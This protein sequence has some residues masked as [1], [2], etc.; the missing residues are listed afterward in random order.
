[1]ICISKLK[2]LLRANPNIIKDND[3]SNRLQENQVI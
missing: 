3:I 2:S 1:M